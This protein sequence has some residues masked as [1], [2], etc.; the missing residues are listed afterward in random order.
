MGKEI[1]TQKLVTPF[2]EKN[3]ISWM[4]EHPKPLMKRDKW[5]SLCGEWELFVKNNKESFVGN[6]MV[7]FPPEARISKIERSLSSG[8][9]YVYKKRFLLP[10]SFCHGRVILHFGAVDAIS[11]VFVNGSFVTRHEGGYTAFECDITPF[12]TDGKNELWVYVKDE[13]D[14]DLCYGKQSKKRGGMWYTPITGIWQSVWLECVPEEYI[15]KLKITPSLDAVTIQTE[16]GKADK[17][18][19]IG[20]KEYSFSG[21]S[22]NIK[23][24]NAVN[25]SPEN[26]YLYNFSITDG[27]DRIESYFALRCVDIKDGYI[28]LNG[29][30]YFFNGVLDQGYFSDGIYTPASPE[31]FVYD[32]L[33]MKKLGFNMLRKHIKIEHDLFYYYCDKY[34]MAVFQDAVNN[35]RY[36]YLLD[37]VLPT[38]GLKK[39]FDR[40]FSARQKEMFVKE[41]TEAAEQL[42]N[43]P[44]LCYWTI[45]NEGWG[46][47]DA[48]FLYEKMKA[49]D[50][51][52]VWDATSGWF[53][54]KKSDVVSEHVYFRKVKLKAKGENPLVLSEF[55]GYS[56]KIAEHS[57]NLDKT[58]GY[59][60]F[61]NKENFENALE[62]LYC[63]GIIPSVKGGLCAC[64]LTQ[65]SDVEDETNGLVTYDRCVVKVDEGRMQ[66]IA[67]KVYDAFSERVKNEK[68]QD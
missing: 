36:N 9:G 2:E 59:G 46:Q 33:T 23:I 64:V 15:K 42:Y 19:I 51:T 53:K 34:G 16:G 18:V 45:F 6:V 62:K 49:L 56:Y 17:R 35:G 38:V 66:Q 60:K 52:R 1:R 13:T 7:P 30:P 20:D 39:A 28:R 37:T 43:H 55:G 63:E 61:E 8:E 4:S 48:D 25:W 40:V 24:E 57:Y 3:T 32:I 58:Y 10:E 50:P 67:K 27:E 31:G 47:F 21:D 22:I 54:K 5:M 44:S 65:L 68:N 12:L 26:P 11:E 14:L 29:K 41:L